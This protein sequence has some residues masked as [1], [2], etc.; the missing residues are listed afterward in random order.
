M[1]ATQIGQSKP[2]SRF[3]YHSSTLIPPAIKPAMSTTAES[4]SS[5]ALHRISDFPRAR[6]RNSPK[7]ASADA[8]SVERRHFIVVSIQELE[9]LP[10]FKRSLPNSVI[11]AFYHSLLT[12]P[13]M[14]IFRFVL[15]ALC[16]LGSWLRQRRRRQRD[17]SNP[18]RAVAAQTA[19]F[20]SRSADKRIRALLSIPTS[21]RPPGQGN[22]SRR[23]SAPGRRGLAIYTD[24]LRYDKHQDEIKHKERPHLATRD[25]LECTSLC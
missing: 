21:S 7:A 19:T 5:A 8:G 11:C 17:A 12:I 23:Y 9:V 20:S 16:F 2:R 15:M 24:W 3:E 22:R 14:R 6:T 4:S 10:S 25:L 1:H 13:I 18:A